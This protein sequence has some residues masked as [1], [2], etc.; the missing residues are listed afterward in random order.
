MIYDPVNDE[1]YHSLSG[2]GAFRNETP[3]RVS[4]AAKLEEAHVG[5]GYSYRRPVKEHAS[6]VEACLTAHCE[7]SRTGSGALSLAYVADG[8]FDGYWEGHMNSWDAA[9]GL[10]IVREAGGWI[11]DFFAGDG[12]NSGNPILAATPALANAFKKLFSF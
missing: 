3:I 9:G 10:A 4:Q 7:Y 2:N 8:R 1:L 11:S 12:L 6:A 5:L